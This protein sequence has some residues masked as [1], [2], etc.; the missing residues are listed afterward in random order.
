MLTEIDSILQQGK[1]DLEGSNTETELDQFHIKYFGKNGQLTE[2]ASKMKDL[3]KEDKPLAGKK[4]NEVRSALTEKFEEKKKTQQEAADLASFQNIDVTLP[5]RRLH[6]GAIHPVNAMRDK[7]IQI[8]RQMGFALVTGPEIETE[9][10][11]F[12]A[13]NTPE[14]HPARNESDTF[15]FQDG[16][17][18][19][20]HTSSVQIRTMEEAKKTPIRI[21]APGSAYRR[22]EIDATHL[23]VFHQFEGLYVNENI[24]LGDLKGTL[25]NFLKNMFGDQTQVRFR[26]H[27]FPFTE[28]S[29]EI[30][31]KLE[32][33]GKDSKWIE[34]AGCGMVDPAVFEA[35]CK[36][37]NDNLFDID[38]VTGFAFGM[39]LE[40]LAMIHGAIPDIRH[41]INNDSRFLT[42]FSK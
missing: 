25:T 37:R 31:I 34:I 42:Q 26:P 39:G 11:C 32:I 12:D 18:L 24:T 15:Y 7:A 40:R 38:R 4:L 29:Y 17:L 30:D 35:I 23:C 2:V 19:R 28:P 33:D 5:G 20:T 27:F 36:K 6:Q 3:S 16:K 21:I 1:T 22:D 41:L 14:D 10:H 8:F 9:W 13:L